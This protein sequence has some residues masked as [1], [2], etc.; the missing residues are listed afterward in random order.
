MRTAIALICALVALAAVPAVAGAAGTGEIEGKVV[1]AG[2]HPLGAIG[3][4]ATL[5]GGGASCGTTEQGTGKYVIGALAEG[6]YEVSFSSGPSHIYL[7]QFYDDKESQSEANL[8]PVVEGETTGNID[9]VMH[10][11]G[12][13]SGNVT[14]R[15]DGAPIAGITAC[16]YEAGGSPLE[17]HDTDS[18]GNYEITGLYSGEYEVHFFVGADC[19]C[20]SLHYVAQITEPFE[21]TAGA[22]TSGIDAVMVSANKHKLSIALTGEGTG[23]VT[24][25]PA[26]I[27]CG[28][29]CVG[30]F[31]ETQMVTLTATAASGSAFAG[32]TGGGCGEAPTCQV[33]IDRDT[34]VSARFARSISGPDPKGGDVQPLPPPPNHPLPL[35]PAPGTSLLGARIDAAKRTAT[36]RFRGSGTVSGFQCR[37]VRP[38]AKGGKAK[39]PP[40]KFGGCTSPKT[41]GHLAPGRYV[42]SVRALGLG[43]TDPTPVTHRFRIPAN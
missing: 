7:A 8:V 32:W 11:G 22:K 14:A 40:A 27:E 5:S 42:F 36:F 1:D 21:V 26:G 24:S 4:C 43:G 34:S 23:T 33:E 15:S 39:R 28:P 3:V 38:P 35:P 10:E 9:A 30:E 16:A 2:N 41:Y 29:L 31:N 20:E 37:L 6:A 19:G 18:D 12:R 13:I 25:A 17:C